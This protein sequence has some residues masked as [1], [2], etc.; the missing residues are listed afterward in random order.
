M[1]LQKYPLSMHK[2]N[3]RL[4]YLIIYKIYSKMYQKMWSKIIGGGFMV[5]A[6]SHYLRCLPSILEHLVSLW[7]FSCY[8][9]PKEATNDPDSSIIPAAHVEDP[10]G[11]L[12]SWLHPGQAL[13]S[14]SRLQCESED[15]MS[16]PFCSSVYVFQIKIQ[17][18]FYK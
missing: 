12:G 15:R 4:L 18:K 11:C 16:V 13:A 7:S 1:V 9:A 17:A 5:Q 2:Q 10:D 14:W 3:M 8:C 6:L